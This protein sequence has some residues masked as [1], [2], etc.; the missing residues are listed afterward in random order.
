MYGISWRCCNAI[1]ETVLTPTLSMTYSVHW[2]NKN[3]QIFVEVDH[4]TEKQVAT[5]AAS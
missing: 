2:Y 1:T 3:N 4:E 5:S